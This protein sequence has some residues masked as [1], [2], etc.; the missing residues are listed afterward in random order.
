M[1]RANIDHVDFLQSMWSQLVAHLLVFFMVQL[2]WFCDTRHYS[3]ALLPFTVIRY[4][5]LALVSMKER[6]SEQFTSKTLAPTCLSS[7]F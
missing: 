3:F 7:T 5:Y 2:V 4:W 1:G 6:D